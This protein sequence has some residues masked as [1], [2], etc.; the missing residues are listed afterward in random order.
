MAI[1]KREIRREPEKRYAV[2]EVS[3]ATG[4]SENTIY[5]YFSNRKITTKD[6]LTLDQI[7]EV[8]LSRRRGSG[9]DWNKVR[10]IERRLDQEKGISVIR[11]NERPAEKAVTW[12]ADQI[13]I[14]EV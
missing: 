5:A 11:E 7:E 10:E 8:C 4:I 1:V 13:S 9:I 12:I 14:E 2:P 3:Q 6:G